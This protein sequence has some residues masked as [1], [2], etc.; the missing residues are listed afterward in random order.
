M[1]GEQ[2]LL[3]ENKGEMLLNQEKKQCCFQDLN[4]VSENDEPERKSKETTNRNNVSQQC[5]LF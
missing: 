5:F 1:L 4:F 2:I 3:L